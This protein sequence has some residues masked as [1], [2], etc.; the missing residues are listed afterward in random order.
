MSLSKQPA[1]RRVIDWLE[2]RQRLA[3]F[4]RRFCRGAFRPGIHTAILSAPR[5]AG[6]S[7][8][9]GELLAAALDPSGPLHVPGGE[10]VLLAGS[11]DQARAVFRFLRQRC[12]GPEFRYLDSGQRVGATHVPTHTRVRVASS[13]AK[14]AFGIVGARLIVGDEPAAWME[15]GG[16]LMFD[17]LSTS[18]G[19]TE[20]TL[21]L[22]GTKAPAPEGNWWR[23]LVDTGTEPGTYVQ[24]HHAPEVDEDGD[25]PGWSSWKTIRRANPLI[26][27]NPFLRPKLEDERRKARKD[28][29]ARRRFISYRLNRP[30]QPAR[31]VLFTVTQW[32]RV[33]A[34][35]VPVPVGR[36]IAGIDTGSSRSW[37]TA[38][39][40]WP[41]GRLDGFAIMPGL[42]DV[43]AQEARDAKSRGRYQSLMDDGRLEVDEGRRVVRV[44]TLINRVMAFRPRCIV[45][46]S[47][48]FREVLD[49]VKG[50]APVIQRRMRQSWSEPTEQI[51]ATRRL[52]LDGA[53]A[54]V[55]EARRLFR[56]SLAESSVEHDSSGNVRLVK[57]DENSRTRDDLAAALVLAC[58]QMARQPVHRPARVTVLGRA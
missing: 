32:R 16:S 7:S 2:Q 19:K 49:A 33:E 57:L 47:F 14:R 42:P 23:R 39:L 24:V 21:I 44:E 41:N 1:G 35:P 48:R 38:A 52:A 17:A 43:Q 27:F 53:L 8:L 22:I 45:T 36:P 51:Q 56:F 10:S 34:R 37:S 4:Q 58:G 30:Q 11:L 12:D 29:D 9:S 54:V 40:L 3:P 13:D 31:S 46:D 20:T 50:R 28:E 25:V 15:R 26:D 5:G 55:P 6:K 18:G